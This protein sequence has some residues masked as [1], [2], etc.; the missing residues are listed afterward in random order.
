M[1]VWMLQ[2]CR[3]PLKQS[4]VH[5][6]HI[7][8]H[9][10]EGHILVGTQSA[11]GC[12][13]TFIH[14]SI[15]NMH[16]FSSTHSGGICLSLPPSRFIPCSA[17]LISRTRTPGIEVPTCGEN[18][19][20]NFLRPWSEEEEGA[21]CNGGFSSVFHPRCFWPSLNAAQS[22]WEKVCSLGGRRVLI[23]VF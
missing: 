3:G 13:C 7:F 22:C 16:L 11:S 21:V 1:C 23:I 4:R 19:E 5:L 6:M 12:L 10:T 8:C 2:R 20:R 17:A 9:W 14:P 15:L 18:A